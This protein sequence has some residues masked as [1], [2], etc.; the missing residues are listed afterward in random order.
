[1]ITDIRGT[2]D[3]GL[4]TGVQSA[5]LQYTRQS[6]AGQLYVAS[7]IEWL[8]NAGFVY[9]ANLPD[10]L[11][12]SNAVTGAT[13]AG[14]SDID[15]DEPDMVIACPSGYFLVPIE[16]I[17]NFLTPDLDADLE[18]IDVLITMDVTNTNT[19][20]QLETAGALGN[21]RNLLDG[22]PAAPGSYGYTCTT[23]LTT[24]PANEHI[25]FAATK[26]LHLTTSG[27]AVSDGHIVWQPPYLGKY[28][29]DCQMVVYAGCTASVTVLAA[30]VVAFV[31]SSFYPTS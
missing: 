17:V 12:G 29:G 20:G 23:A 28:A 22:G 13:A 5:G 1:M 2:V 31:P 30:A 21:L 7:E 4:P 14:A 8:V 10:T 3:S 16:V 11:S 26:T 19:G 9:R 18:T 25:M 15:L 24:D 6:K 27:G